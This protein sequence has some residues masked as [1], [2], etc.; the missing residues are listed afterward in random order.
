MAECVIY[1]LITPVR[2]LDAAEHARTV[3][4]PALVAVVLLG[5]CICRDW[6][7][8]SRVDR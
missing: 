2:K 6:R 8:F 3:S 5:D 1:S 7:D 4:A